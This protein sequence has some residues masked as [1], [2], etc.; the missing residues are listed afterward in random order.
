VIFGSGVIKRAKVGIDSKLWRSYVHLQN[1]E[2]DV[3]QGRLEPNK[4]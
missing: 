4:P 3:D 1:I 2:R